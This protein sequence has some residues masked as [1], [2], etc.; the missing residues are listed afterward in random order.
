MNTT[1][2]GLITAI[3]AMVLVW[4]IRR[5]GTEEEVKRAAWLFKILERDNSQIILPATA[6]SE[7]LIPYRPSE[8][9]DVIA[10][11][12]RRFFLAP[13]DVKCA[14]LAARLFSIGK[15]ERHM[16]KRNARK[17]LKSDAYIVATAAVHGARLFYSNDK[18]CRKLAEKAGL[19]A[20][21]LPD[22]APDLFS[23]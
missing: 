9:A 13:F 23:Q 18:W 20:R 14:A 15:A 1:D 2:A 5:D 11:L 3:D 10:Q 7:Y 19:T 4:G 8:H 17:L 21:D 6:L 22:I 12:S 16:G